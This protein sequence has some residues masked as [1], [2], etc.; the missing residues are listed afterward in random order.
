MIVGNGATTFL[1]WELTLWG[2]PV[3]DLAVHLHKMAYLPEEEASL[4]TRWSSAMPSEHIVGWQDDLV[5]YRTHERIKSAIVDAVRYSQL[6]AQGGSY[7]EDQLID[8]MTAK[9]NAARPHWHI[10]APIDPRTVERALRP[11]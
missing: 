5:A 4:T 1:D 3:Y 7:P 2:D 6:F 9:L 11:H 10:P 8:T